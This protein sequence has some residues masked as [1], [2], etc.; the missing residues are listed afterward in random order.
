M[1]TAVNNVMLQSRRKFPEMN[2]VYTSAVNNGNTIGIGIF[3]LQS[4]RKFA[5]RIATTGDAHVI[6]IR[7]AL[8]LVNTRDTTKHKPFQIYSS[9]RTTIER[10]MGQKSTLPCVRYSNNTIA[11]KL[12]VLGLTSDMYDAYYLQ[13][14]HIK[15]RLSIVNF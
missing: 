11:N 4:G 7:L 1:N 6:A 8:H 9:C 15:S 10:I 3:M 14:P 5:A 13:L 2:S 12:A